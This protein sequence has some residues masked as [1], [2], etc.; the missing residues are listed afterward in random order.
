MDGRAV[1]DLFIVYPSAAGKEREVYTTLRYFDPKS[2]TWRATFI[3]PKDASVARFTDGAVG[4]NRIVFQSQDFGGKE[5]R[6]SFNDIHLDSFV[7]REEESG[8]GGKTWRLQA[9]HHMKRRGAAP[10]AQ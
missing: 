2:G 3:D 5:T 8:D 9:E 10:P 7:W 6:W 1:Q 4:D